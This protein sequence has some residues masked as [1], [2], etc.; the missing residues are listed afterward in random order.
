[1]DNLLHF[2]CLALSRVHSFEC[3]D[4]IFF[5]VWLMSL[6]LVFFCLFQSGHVAQ[7]PSHTLSDQ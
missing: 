4:L 3:L 6:F 1:M 7:A 5:A 2:Y